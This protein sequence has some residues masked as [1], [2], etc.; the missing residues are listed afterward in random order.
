MSK[1]T[2]TPWCDLADPLLSKK[3]HSV[4]SKSIHSLLNILF[5][6]HL[7]Q[8]AHANGNPLP[9]H[10]ISHMIPGQE[11]PFPL[12]PQ[13]LWG[14]GD[15]SFLVSGY[16]YFGQ[17]AH[18]ELGMVGPTGVWLLT[19]ES[20]RLILITHQDV[21]LISHAGGVAVHNQKLYIA[22]G[23]DGSVYRGDWDA[24][25]RI[26]EV[27]RI[28]QSPV[29]SSFL[30]VDEEGIIWVGQFFRESGKSLGEW[31][32]GAHTWKALAIAF[33]ADSFRPQRA[34]ALRQLV[35]GLAFTGEHMILSLSWGQRNPSALAVYPDPRKVD[36]QER[37]KLPDGTEIPL[38]LPLGRIAEYRLPPMSEEIWVAPGQNV[39]W[40]AFESGAIRRFP[41]VREG[42]RNPRI[43]GFELPVSPKAISE[44]GIIPQRP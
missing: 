23:S 16:Q 13:G 33:D 44:I 12:I 19:P 40:V 6:L 1:I 10:T 26:I 17:P 36:A 39:V 32:S 25:A 41:R 8:A 7:V 22:G 15:G 9:V 4:A 38:Y 29:P 34:V 18:P 27:E 11:D 2:K 31:Q 14:F 30:T 5:A 20:A 37:L 21:P 24:E 42:E 28:F 35:Q 43:L 3:I